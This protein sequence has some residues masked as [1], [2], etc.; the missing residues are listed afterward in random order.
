MIEFKKKRK[1]LFAAILTLFYIIAGVVVVHNF[2]SLIGYVVFF[3]IF[4]SSM[5][6]GYIEDL[7]VIV[8]LIIYFIE[9]TI[10]FFLF[11]GIVHIILKTKN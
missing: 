11:Y 10:I 6:F 9:A 7:S 3:P 8:I 1:I 5:L 4:L 2:Q